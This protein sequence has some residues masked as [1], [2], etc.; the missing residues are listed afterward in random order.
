MVATKAGFVNGKEV[1]QVQ[2][3]PKRQV[4]KKKFWRRAEI[5]FS[6]DTVYLDKTQKLDASVQI[7][8]KS[9]SDSEKIE[10]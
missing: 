5:G 7:E 8:R 1:V 3:D 4:Q 9:G 6:T 2:F 10:K